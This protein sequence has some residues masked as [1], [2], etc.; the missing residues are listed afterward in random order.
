MSSVF[1]KGLKTKVLS[2]YALEHMNF[3]GYWKNSS[4]SVRNI[5]LVQDSL[6]PDFLGFGKNYVSD[7]LTHIWS[8]WYRMF[9]EKADSH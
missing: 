4:I 6:V 5:G 8:P 2:K 3:Y 7:C 9:P 1:I